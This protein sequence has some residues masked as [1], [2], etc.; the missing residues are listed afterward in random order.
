M[1]LVVVQVVI[2]MTIVSLAT[3]TAATVS[4]VSPRGIQTT[5]PKNIKNKD[6]NLENILLPF[7]GSRFARLVR[8]GRRRQALIPKDLPLQLSY[9]HDSDSDSDY[10]TVA[11]G[12]RSE[13]ILP[14]PLPHRH[15]TRKYCQHCL[16][17]AL[18]GFRGGG[19]L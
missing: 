16:P 7:L 12:R 1:P 9:H 15:R 19:F 8:R 6:K 3:A 17:L 14:P 10:S 5:M 2:T 18:Y 11:A 4:I 13:T